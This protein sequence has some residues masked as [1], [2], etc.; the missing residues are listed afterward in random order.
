MF[1]RRSFGP[2]IAFARTHLPNLWL[3]FCSSESVQMPRLFD[4]Q[5]KVM[6]PSASL[7]YFTAF[8]LDRRFALDT[9]E[10]SKTYK[11]LQKKLHPDLF[12]L[13]QEEEQEVPR[14][15]KQAGGS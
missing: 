5:G 9:E 7:D 13:K 4:D 14:S 12:S 15:R 1:L 11:A 2:H 8:G 3:R 6:K 10:L